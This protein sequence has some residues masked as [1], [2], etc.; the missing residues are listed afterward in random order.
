MALQHE[1]S[2]FKGGESEALKRLKQ[3][4]DDKVRFLYL[5]SRYLEFILLSALMELIFGSPNYNNV[6][7]LLRI[8]I[9]PFLAVFHC[10]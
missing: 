1:F 4:L 7:G 8:P 5:S 3:S 6:F 9:E 10:E 2:P